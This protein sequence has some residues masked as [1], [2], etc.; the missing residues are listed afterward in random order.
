MQL[1]IEA[2][3]TFTADIV[4][5]DDVGFTA[6]FKAI[7]PWELGKAVPEDASLDV[8]AVFITNEVIELVTDWQGVNDEQGEPIP[9]SKKALLSLFKLPYRLVEKLV[10]AYQ[11]AYGVA[12]SKN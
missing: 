7:P 9:F 4:I 11:D 12:A 2:N 1:V 8:A 10:V 6:T 3:P 5:A